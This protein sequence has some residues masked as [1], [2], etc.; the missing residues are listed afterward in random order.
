MDIH[1]TLHHQCV[2][3]IQSAFIVW[4]YRNH[5]Y[6]AHPPSSMCGPN[7]VSLQASLYGNIETTHTLLIL[8]RQCV[9]QIW[10]TFIVWQYR[11]HTYTTYPPSSMC[12]ANMASLHCMA[13]QKP[14][15][16]YTPFIINIWT[17]Y[18][19]PSL[20]GYIEA[21]HTLHTLSIVNVLTN[22]SQPSLY[23]NIETTHYT[24]SIVNVW[25]KYGQPLGFIVWQYINHTYTTHPPSSMCGP[26]MAS[27]HRMATQKPHIHYTPSIVNVW[28]KYDQL[29]LY[30]NIDTTHTVH[31]LHRQ[32]VEQIWP[33][34]IVWQYINHIYTI[35]P[36]S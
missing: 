5:T 23:G 18:G 14:H 9:D 10:S 1:Y 17:K 33:A 21:T 15:I 36:P 7:M 30:G 12:G 22:Y 28:T 19:Q 34:F 3:Q 29:S 27:L 31:T 25:T 13:I 16:H 4:Q 32:C 8:H 26:N 11:Y 2:D 6:T 20:Y 35:H 24:S